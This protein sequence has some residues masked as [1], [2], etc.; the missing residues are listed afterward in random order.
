MNTSPTSQPATHSPLPWVHIPEDNIILSTGDG[1]IIEWQ[2]R[3]TAVSVEKRDANAAYI[4]TACNEYP[5]ALAKIDEQQRRIAELEGAL[6]DAEKL[7]RIARNYF[8]KSIK[9]ADKFQLENT[10]ATIG[11]ALSTLPTP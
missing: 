4:V 10:C 11:K 6:R 8:P 2:A 5:Q 3:S 9:Q 1:K 7:I